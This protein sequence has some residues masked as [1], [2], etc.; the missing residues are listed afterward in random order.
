MM[1]LYGLG[2]LIVF[3]QTAPETVVANLYRAAKT[4][5]IAGMSKTELRTYFDAELTTSIWKATHSE[6]G[7]DFDILYNAQDAGT[8]NF[9]IGESEIQ[10]PSLATVDVSFDNFGKKEE[11]QFLMASYGKEGWKVTEIYYDQGMLSE[12]L[13][14]Y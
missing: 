8:R 9:R 2:N 6:D 12:I 10:S 1:I 14:S 13:S 5:S 3:A 7:L 11:I 4:K